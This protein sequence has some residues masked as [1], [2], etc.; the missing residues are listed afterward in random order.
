LTVS[1]TPRT[2]P[3]APTLTATPAA[4]SVSLSWT[5]PADGGASIDHY[6]I[7][8]YAGSSATGT[9]TTT[10][11]TTSTTQT[12]AGLTNGTTYTFGI[13]AVN[14][15][16]PSDPSN[17]ETATP[18]TV[19]TAPKLL[20]TVAGP[21]I[22]EVVWSP[23]AGDGGAAI[24]AYDIFRST[25]A[26]SRGTQIAS[27]APASSTNSYIDQSVTNGTTYYYEVVAVNRAGQ[28]P[29][30]EQ[31]S[32]EPQSS[33][34]SLVLVKSITIDRHKVTFS[35]P[36]VCVRAG[37][38]TGKLTISSL[39]A[40]SPQMLISRAAFKVGKLAKKTVIRPKPFSSSI[41]VKLR[42]RRMLAKHNYGF[43]AEPSIAIGKGAP[44]RH[45]LRLKITAC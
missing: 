38:V 39:K 13:E 3:D 14:A 35:A 8:E 30:S 19:P 6:V 1:T 4:G 31:F 16:G 12:I 28:S 37:R 10:S 18:A 27:Q 34:P 33:L 32:A 26:G 45:T 11:T 15:A 17:F 23:P 36:N 9:P 21:A 20:A 41:R 2:V 42:A 7:E 22:A 24:G 29:A 40:H 43:L 25:T 5:A 44:Q